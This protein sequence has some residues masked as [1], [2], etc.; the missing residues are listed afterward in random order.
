WIL[1]RLTKLSKRLLHAYREYQFHIVYHGLYS[2]CVV[3]LSSLY[4]DILKDR[5]YVSHPRSP[6]RK[7]SQTAIFH[8]LNTLVRLMAPVISFTAEE[9]WDHMPIKNKKESIHLETF[10]PVDE[11][12]LLPDLEE[13][14]ERLWRIREEANK[15]LEE[16]R[17]AKEIGHSLDAVLTIAGDEDN[18]RFL[19][20]FEEL[21][22]LFI[23]SIVN[24]RDLKDLG[25]EHNTAIDGLRIKVELSPFKKCDRCWIKDQTVIQV[26]GHGNL[27]KRCIHVLEELK[28]LS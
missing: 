28:V 23:V 3:D 2:F 24:L 20:S 18:L 4:L 25:P 22:E 5:L 9:I 11:M 21:R 16:K 14:W 12:L 17:K 6:K 13:R 8:I 15:V 7:S 1:S 19:R 26:Q 10:L 27:C